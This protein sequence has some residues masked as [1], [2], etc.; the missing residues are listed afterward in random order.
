MLACVCVCLWNRMVVFKRPS[1]G[2]HEM[3]NTQ[4]KS[5]ARGGEFK[6]GLYNKE[7]AIQN[8]AGF[9]DFYMTWTLSH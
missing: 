9:N 3:G 8:I 4:M 5:P 1:A 7:S 6:W 2:S